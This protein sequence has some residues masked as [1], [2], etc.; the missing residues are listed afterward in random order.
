MAHKRSRAA[1]EADLHAPYALFGTPLPPLDDNA[2][3]DGSYVPVWKQDVTDDR[4]RKR[5]H[6]AF[7]GGFSAG[8]FNTVG[9]KEGWTPSTFV[10][11]RANRHKDQNNAAQARPEDYMD[12]EDLADAREA[13][14]IQTAGAFSGFGTAGEAAAL[15][16]VLM[17]MIKTTGETM[18][19]KLLQKMGWKPGQGVGPRIRR[20]ARLDP[21]EEAGQDAGQQMHLFAPDNSK[22]IT[23]RRKNDHK[24][25]GYEGEARLSEPTK[26]DKAAEEEES[27][28]ERDF[29]S[30]GAPRKPKAK[31]AKRGGFGV[32]VLN[33]TGSDE[34]DPYEMGPKISYN[35]VIGGD[36]KT[37]K[38]VGT[39]KPSLG[40]ANPL[41]GAKPVFISK[42]ARKPE[43]GFRKC[44]DGRFPLDGF[45]L[46][47]QALSISD[48]AK[49]AP[50]SIPE[51]WS[52]SKKAASVTS[53]TAASYQSTSDAAKA[54][55][56]DAKARAAL[57][58]EAALPGKSVFDFVSPAARARL[59]ASTG[60]ANLPQA[61]GEA[62]PEGF[63][64]TDAARHQDLWNMVPALDATTA[65]QALRR[66]SSG[67]MPYADDAGKRA[68]YRGF[69]ELRAGAREDPALPERPP[70]MRVAEWAQELREFAHA[71]QVFKPVTGMMA[72]RF[73]TASTQHPAASSGES[74]PTTTASATLTTPAPP[75]PKSPAEEAAALGMFGP[76]T[77]SR[78]PFFP[79]RLLCKRF[80]VPVPAHVR[81]GPDEARSSAAGG[82]DAPT[83]PDLEVVKK[84]AM[85]EMM[86]EGQLRGSYGSGG[87]GGGGAGATTRNEALETQ[88][89]GADLFKAVFGSDDEDE[90]D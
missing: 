60:N 28:G 73:T 26:A 38:K 66:G 43:A 90:D 50:P 45:I 17:G 18:G 31:P 87:G 2:R 24:G 85:E 9:S 59:V 37:K 11:S 57:L 79:A 52:S 12:D 64:K 58:G 74:T 4:G 29:G 77:R 22:M 44:H 48:G 34:E 39:T 89:A 76:L 78:A 8:Y 20:K 61:L 5:L 36:K 51:G 33:D 70:G 80:N 67:W 75:K 49:W 72:S 62:A 6:G 3:D 71:A 30:L 40:S 16:N 35:R 55:T 63:R 41:L 68:R 53:P 7:T 82:A 42:K 19:V 65:E 86:R 56:L 54:S 27:N 15:Q 47:T 14:K 84:A 1:F 21:G 23:F 10:S 81:P 25:L 13:E 69:L 46:A 83:P 32:G 88:K